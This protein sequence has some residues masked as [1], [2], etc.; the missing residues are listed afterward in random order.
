M[1]KKDEG[2]LQLN[3]MTKAYMKLKDELSDAHSTINKQSNEIRR[4]N[5]II[6]DLGREEDVQMLVLPVGSR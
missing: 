3:H 5:K 2:V 4:L 1:N 6:T